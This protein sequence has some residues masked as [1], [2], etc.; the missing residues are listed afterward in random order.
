MGP[1]R[2][3]QKVMPASVYGKFISDACFR[4]VL[5]CPPHVLIMASWPGPTCFSNLNPLNP[6]P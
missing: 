6:K 5:A 1:C 2:M 4:M 3:A